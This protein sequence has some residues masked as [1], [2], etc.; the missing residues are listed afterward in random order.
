[1]TSIYIE[2]IN[3]DGEEVN[4]IF[5]PAGT[6]LTINLGTQTLPFEFDPYLLV[7]PMEVYG[8]YTF[9][10]LSGDCTLILNVP[11][12]T[13]TP[14]PTITPTRTVTPT[15]TITPT[16]SSSYDPCQITPTPTTTPTITVTRTPTRTPTPT[17]TSTCPGPTPTPTPSAKPE[18]SKI[19][20]GKFSGTS[21]TSAETTSF[22][23]G[24][25]NNPTN[26]AVILPSGSSS[27]YGY[28][29]IP[30]GLTQPS[31]FRDSSA[32]C[33]GNNIPFNNIGTIN[34]LDANGFSIT[35]NVY[36][37]FF[38]FVTNVSVWMCS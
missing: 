9:L 5:N 34:I 24:Y 26:G 6:S 36:R 28:I 23:S 14:T 2:S 27:E 32:G 11:A 30:M 20:W 1:M 15:P 8:T 31:D 4:V 22:S 7:P 16:P 37:T 13:S 3:Y 21:V 12:P 29:L 19:Y 38:P 10:T 25:T 35:Y 17:P 33:F 18:A